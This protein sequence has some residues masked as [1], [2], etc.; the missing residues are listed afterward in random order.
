MSLILTDEELRTARDCIE[1]LLGMHLH[2]DYDAE[3]LSDKITAY[4]NEKEE[5][6]V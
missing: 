3:A 2:A 1:E 6:N 4:F 5:T